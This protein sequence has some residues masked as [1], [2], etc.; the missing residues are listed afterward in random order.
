MFIVAHLLLDE[1]V[2]VDTVQLAVCDDTGENVRYIPVNCLESEEVGERREVAF[3]DTFVTAIV[4]DENRHKVK[5]DTTQCAII[6]TAY[7]DVAELKF[8]TISIF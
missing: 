3:G 1:E 7:D 2:D 5:T 8:N 4:C 6:Q